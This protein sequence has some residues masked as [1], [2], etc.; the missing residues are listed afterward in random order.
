MAEIKMFFEFW[1]VLARY[2]VDEGVVAMISVSS[3]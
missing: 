3:R 1:P 2:L